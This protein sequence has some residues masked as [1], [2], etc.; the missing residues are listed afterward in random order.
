LPA[1]VDG[2]PQRRLERLL[3]LEHRRRRDLDGGGRHLRGD[4]G[5]LVQDGCRLLVTLWR[6]R[7]D[8]HHVRREVRGDLRSR[9]LLLDRTRRN[10]A[11]SPKLTGPD[12]GS[13]ARSTPLSARARD[14]G[15]YTL[16]KRYPIDLRNSTLNSRETVPFVGQC[17][18]SPDT[19]VALST[20]SSTS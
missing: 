14:S 12:L 3:S 8:R 15:P 9:G 11:Q 16:E 1:D 20:L 4:D 6:L 5:A 18:F 10:L 7:R 17:R 13:C 2:Q 19:S